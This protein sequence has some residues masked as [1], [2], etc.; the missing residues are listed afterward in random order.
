[1][2]AQPI[3]VFV[4]CTRIMIHIG[5]SK[6]R[7]MPRDAFAKAGET[8]AQAAYTHQAKDEYENAIEFYES[9]APQVQ[10]AGERKKWDALYDYATNKLQQL[11]D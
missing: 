1:M 11:F 10:D 2:L 3:C 6:Q 9:S 7:F 8:L 4:I 5:H